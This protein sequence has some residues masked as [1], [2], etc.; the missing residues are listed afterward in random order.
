MIPTWERGHQ[1]N[2]FHLVQTKAHLQ[3]QGMRLCLRECAEATRSADYS[4]IYSYYL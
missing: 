3:V 4:V 1:S 2:F